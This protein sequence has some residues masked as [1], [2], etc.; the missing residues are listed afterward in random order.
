MTQLT[1]E[2]E[3]LRREKADLLGEVEAHKVM[4]RLSHATVT[5][6]CVMF[7]SERNLETLKGRYIMCL[8]AKSRAHKNGWLE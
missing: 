1:T 5:I 8:C 3:Q 2:V 7:I 6:S 4:V